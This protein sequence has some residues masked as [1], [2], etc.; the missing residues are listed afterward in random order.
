M[1]CRKTSVRIDEELLSA[2]REALGTDTIRETIDRALREVLRARA[3]AAEVR[4]LA[5]MEGLDLADADVMA[6]AWRR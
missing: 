3:R 5:T 6:G 1:G 2:A 4:A